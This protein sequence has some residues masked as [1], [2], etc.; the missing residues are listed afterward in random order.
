MSKKIEKYIDNNLPKVEKEVILDY[1]VILP[2][3]IIKENEEED[4]LSFIEIAKPLPISSAHFTQIPGIVTSIDNNMLQVKEGSILKDITMLPPSIIEEDEEE[5]ALSFIDITK[6]LSISSAHLTKTEVPDTL[7]IQQDLRRLAVTLK[8]GDHTDGVKKEL[9][10]KTLS[11]LSKKPSEHLNKKELPQEIIDLISENKGIIEYIFVTKQLPTQVL[12]KINTYLSKNFDYSFMLFKGSLEPKISLKEGSNIVLTDFYT[13]VTDSSKAIV[14]RNLEQGLS[15]LA[16]NPIIKTLIEIN[17]GHE[18]FLYNLSLKDY[19][20]IDM[21]INGMAITGP[22]VIL[23]GGTKSYVETSP[24]H[25]LK[26]PSIVLHEMVHIAMG[27]L[28]NNCQ[29][30]YSLKSQ[31]NFLEDYKVYFS[32]RLALG[33]TYDALKVTEEQE[34]TLEQQ[35]LKQNLGFL[36]SYG[37]EQRDKEII[38]HYFEYLADSILDNSFFDTTV[39]SG[40]ADFIKKYVAPKADKYLSIKEKIQCFMDDLESFT[41]NQTNLTHIIMGYIDIDEIEGS[42]VIQSIDVLG[43][44]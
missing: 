7:K 27:I 31:E 12:S 2:A 32:A 43:E 5:D 17:Q 28:F 37:S 21:N 1:A 4:A 18:K 33:N 23:V 41:H 35:K 11:F 40:V 44:T 39:W 13:D 8:K 24:T 29:N 36:F 10:K 26:L 6:P 25:S 3:S 22:D 9:L 14:V 16:S 34:L 42:P 38:S 19:I 30:P 20:G 15:K